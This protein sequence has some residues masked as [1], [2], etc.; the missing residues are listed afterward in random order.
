[1]K[2]PTTRKALLSAVS[3]AALLGVGAGV[4]FAAVPA[5]KAIPLKDATGNAITIIAGTGEG[6]AY[7]V[8]T[9]CFGTAGCHG[10]GSGTLQYGYDAI[11]RH[12][13][14]AQLG[15]SELKGFNAGNPD[16]DAWR[17]GA[18]PGKKNWVQSPGHVG[19]W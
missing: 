3:C 15:A 14:H 11:E 12:S 5:H 17:A 7:S 8:K 6:K 4:A 13:Y 19:S 16:A 18:G 10:N 1:M 2:Q 9:T